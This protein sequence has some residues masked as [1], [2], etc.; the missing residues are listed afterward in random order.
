MRQ[1][2]NRPIV[3]IAPRCLRSTEVKTLLG[4][5]AKA[6]LG[7]TPRT[8]FD[9]LVAEMVREDLK[10]AKRDELIKKH[11]YKVMDYHEQGDARNLPLPWNCDPH[12]FQ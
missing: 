12:V 1:S 2:S 4:E 7:R 9:E 10:S 11:G 6:R 5:P 3:Q 8:S